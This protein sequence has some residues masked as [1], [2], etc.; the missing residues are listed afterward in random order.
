MDILQFVTNNL[1]TLHPIGQFSPDS[2]SERALPCPTDRKAPAG[3]AFWAPGPYTELLSTAEHSPRPEERDSIGDRD[4]VPR[5][6][7]GSVSG[8]VLVSYS[9]TTLS[10]LAPFPV[11]K[12]ES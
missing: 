6:A 12:G 1:K 8:K 10:G 3:S 11:L 7:R 4:A 5:P 2:V 9:H